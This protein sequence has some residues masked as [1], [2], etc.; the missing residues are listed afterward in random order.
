MVISCW[1]KNNNNNK[2]KKEMEARNKRK[3]KRY[4]RIKKEE[5]KQKGKIRV[6]NRKR[7][8]LGFMVTPPLGARVGCLVTLRWVRGWVAGL[9]PAG[10]VGFMVTSR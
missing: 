9:L 4:K 2:L 1:G 3:K 5:N 8:K 7:K 6:K 10:E